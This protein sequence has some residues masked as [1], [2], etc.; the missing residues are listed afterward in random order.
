LLRWDCCDCCA[1][2]TKACPEM[3]KNSAIKTGKNMKK[4]GN[5]SS[6]LTIKHQ[7]GFFHRFTWLPDQNVD[8]STI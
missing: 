8:L 1:R 3:L 7:A 2:A 6:E 5:S 4:M